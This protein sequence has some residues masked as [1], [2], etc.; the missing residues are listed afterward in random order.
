MRIVFIGVSRFGLRCLDRIFQMREFKIAG[1]ITNKKRFT[2]SYAP[3]GVDNVLY[4]NFEEYARRYNLPYYVMKNRMTE[5]EIMEHAK[6]WHPDLI[7]VVGWYHMIPRSLRELA[8]VIGLHASL[9]PDYS[10]GAP[11]VWAMI[12]GEKTTG[13]TLFQFARGVDD[14]PIIS[15]APAEIYQSD[16]IATLYE[17]IEELGLKLLE[18]QLPL[19]AAGK[20]VLLP[21]DENK[22]RVFPQRMPEDGRINWSY[23][24]TKIHDFIRAQ[25]HPYPGAF[26]T[27]DNK[28]VHIWESEPAYSGFQP[29]KPLGF[30][31]KTP[32]NKI[33]VNCGE[34]TILRLKT[35]GVDSKEMPAEEWFKNFLNQLES[36]FI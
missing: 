24:A 25:T 36:A 19:I 13:I 20:A 5:P 31:Y 17:R 3:E 15:Q 16:T 34:N 30:V 1:I 12:N 27:Y 2:I 33:L 23:S 29:E 11:L 26:T 21:Q 4:A 14:G 8:P 7:I 10:G 22:R 18:E 35:I 9:L 32:D 28:I 6:L